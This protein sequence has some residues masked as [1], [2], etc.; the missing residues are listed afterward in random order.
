MTHDNIGPGPLQAIHFLGEVDPRLVPE[1]TAHEVLDLGEVDRNHDD[2]AVVPAA[3]ACV[4]ALVDEPVI[5]AGGLIAHVAEDADGGL[6]QGRFGPEL[7]QPS[8][9]RSRDATRFASGYVAPPNPA[10]FA[11]FAS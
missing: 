11:P 6:A 2:L 1:V 3:Q 7:M 10:Y 9:A 4:Q 5:L 8:L